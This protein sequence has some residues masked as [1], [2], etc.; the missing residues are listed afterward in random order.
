M[1]ETNGKEFYTTQQAEH[2]KQYI[3]LD[4][5]GRPSKT[6]IAAA[7]HPVGAPCEVTVYGYVDTSSTV[8]IARVEKRG[9]WTQ[10]FQD[11]IDL[12]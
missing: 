5:Q 9:T 10:V 11:A 6:Y 8:I 2:V 3:E 7:N 1:S 12:L 4:V